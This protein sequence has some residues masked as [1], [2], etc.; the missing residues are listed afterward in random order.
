MALRMDHGREL[1]PCRL[2]NLGT[3]P[4]TLCFQKLVGSFDPTV[5][6]IASPFD[7]MSPMVIITCGAVQIDLALSKFITIT[8]RVGSSRLTSTSC[9]F[10]MLGMVMWRMLF[11]A[12]INCLG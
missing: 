6:V 1:V 4:G 2:S 11:G 7:A 9:R 12:T 3:R 8:G 10:L 5:G